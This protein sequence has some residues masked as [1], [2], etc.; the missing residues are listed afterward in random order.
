MPKD[1]K[2]IARWVERFTLE[3]MPREKSL[4]EAWWRANTTGRKEDEN[5]AAFREEEYRLLFADPV[6]H[7]ELK[8]LEKDFNAAGPKAAQEE[9]LLARQLRLLKNEFGM[10]Q[11]APEAIRELVARI[12]EIESRFNN[13][14]A[15]FRGQRVSDNR[16]KDILRSSADSEE[17]REAWEASKQIGNEVAPR[18]LDLVRLRNKIAR[19]NGY[20]SYHSQSLSLNELDPKA[21]F[22]LLEELKE[23]TEKPYL[24]M[25][26]KLDAAL[27][28]KFRLPREELRPWHYGDPFFQSAPQ[29]GHLDLDAFYAGKDLLALTIKFFDG[30]GLEIRDI[31]ARS[32]LYEREGKCQHAFCTDIDKD[33]DV[34]VLCNLKPNEHWM[35]TMLHEL[36]HAVYDKYKD[37]RLPYLLRG[38]SHTFTTEAIAMLFGRLPQSAAFL[39]EIAGATPREAEAVGEEAKEQFRQS[40]LIFIRWGLVVILFERELYSNPEQDLNTLWWKLVEDLQRLTPPGGNSRPAGGSNDWAA[41]IHVATSPVYYQNYLLGELLASQLA[42]HLLA[43]RLGNG[44]TIVNQRKAG[45][46]LIESIFRRGRTLPWNELVPAATGEELTPLYFVREFAQ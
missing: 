20:E 42:H 17:A 1:L 14:R 43:V 26:E 40:Q 27:A 29:A 10:H 23:A 3:L 15:T 2:E 18:V 33:G 37:P 4:G 24:A 25:K 6:R 28:R 22:P 35:G 41:K 9:K 39:S 5:E 16:L 11:A 30:L 19:A 12:V 38:P 32:D 46:Y 45:K 13:F 34:R 36:G 31:L 44:R 8:A 21:L 7:A